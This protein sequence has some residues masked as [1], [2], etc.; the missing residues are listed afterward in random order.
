MCVCELQSAIGISQPSGNFS[1]SSG[2][3]IVD[4]IP[5]RNM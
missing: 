4:I 2:V 3:L 5:E 1:I